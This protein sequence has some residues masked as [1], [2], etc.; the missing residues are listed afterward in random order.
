MAALASPR[1]WISPSP[2]CFA[3][4]WRRRRAASVSESKKGEMFRERWTDV[5]QARGYREMATRL[6]R[7]RDFYE[8]RSVADAPPGIAIGRARRD[9]ER[10]VV[11]ERAP[12]SETR[13]GAARRTIS[14]RRRPVGR[15]SWGAGTGRPA[16]R[17]PA[18]PSSIETSSG[19]TRRRTRANT[20]IEP[21]VL[22]ASTA[23]RGRV[24]WFSRLLASAKKTREDEFT[25][26]SRWRCPIAS[27]SR[28]RRRT[29]DA[30]EQGG[31][32]GV[33]QGGE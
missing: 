17:R 25:P 22:A 21:A 9:A 19:A 29:Q 15:W 20:P 2:R 32:A 7:V 13:G 10:R 5:A 12:R 8:C 6:R 33:R 26:R 27:I 11:S 3:T 16:R 23:R 1:V 14:R 30:A 28:A 24:Y 4:R 18:A 31:D